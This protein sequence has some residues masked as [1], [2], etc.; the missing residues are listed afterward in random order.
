MT[1]Q[2]PKLKRLAHR[3]YQ[4]DDIPA[5]HSWLEIHGYQFY[6]Q[7]SPG[8]YGR[9]SHHEVHGH[10]DQRSF[11]N[12]YIQVMDS[13]EI[14]TPDPHAWSLLDSLLDDE[15]RERSV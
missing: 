12:G 2:M 7:H 13:G 11:S 6:G 9:F 4:C 15:L 8:E 14:Y 5:F 3:K 1:Q 10:G